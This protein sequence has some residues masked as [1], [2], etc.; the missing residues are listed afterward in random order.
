M[1]FIITQRRL[2][3]LVRTFPLWREGKFKPGQTY[4]NYFLHDLPFET[5]KRKP[6]GRFN[7]WKLNLRGSP[8]G[9]LVLFVRGKT[10]E[11]IAFASLKGG[12]H[13]TDHLSVPRADGKTPEGY[14]V[15]DPATIKLL[16]APIRQD[17]LPWKEGRTSL[18]AERRPLNL[19]MRGQA[20]YLGDDQGQTES[21]LSLAA[22]HRPEKPDLERPSGGLSF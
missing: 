2:H 14:F 7:H 22:S 9:T 16:G 5:P 15:V 20:W 6:A 11:V 19:G 1:P 10:R 8:D 13:D 4:R 17:D 12:H 3:M 18:T 21:F